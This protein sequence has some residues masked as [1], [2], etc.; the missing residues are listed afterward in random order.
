MDANDSNDEH[1]ELTEADDV[2]GE[3][4]DD[5]VDYRERAAAELDQIAGD[6]RQALKEQGI[7]ISL[8]FLIPNSGHSVIVFGTPTD[9]P[10]ELWNKVGEIVSA[11]VRRAVGLGRTRCRP[12]ICA[13]T[14]SIAYQQPLQSPIQPSEPSGCCSMPMHAPALPHSGVEGR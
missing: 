10:D 6:A 5:E 7:D 14:D 1:D 3:S 8:F 12:V 9:P 13:S 4:M 11:I 2:P